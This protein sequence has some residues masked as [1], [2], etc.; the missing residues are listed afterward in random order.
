MDTWGTGSFE[1][2]AATAFIREV[3]E[4][5]APALEEAFEVT[6]DPDTTELEA[7][8]GARAVAAAETLQAHLTGD[9]ENVS[10]AGL[11][12][13]LG[14]LAPD[15]LAHLRPLAL[16]ALDRVVGPGSE[17]PDAWEE[18]L[19]ASEWIE[20]VQRLRAALGGSIV[21]G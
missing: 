11:R 19:D 14:E 2:E 21:G 16:E 9:T 20:N 10:S 6:L 17:L 4:D 15:E 12:A 7:E 13:W 3:M 5:G 1:N 8:E 18:S